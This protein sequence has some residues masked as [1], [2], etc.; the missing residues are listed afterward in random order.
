MLTVFLALC[1]LPAAM[2]VLATWQGR[3]QYL[4]PLTGEELGG[5]RLRVSM[6]RSAARARQL[7]VDRALRAFEAD[8]LGVHL[9]RVI[10]RLLAAP[11]EG[12]Y[13]AL[14]EAA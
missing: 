8:A 12:A 10:G 13:E 14:R 11:S 3:E 4:A 7:R 6:E 5:M 2:A 9:D 1:A